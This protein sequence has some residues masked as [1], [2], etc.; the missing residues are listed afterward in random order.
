[1]HQRVGQIEIMEAQHA[2]LGLYLEII[3]RPGTLIAIAATA[4]TATTAPATP[5]VADGFV[6]LFVLI[7][8]CCLLLR[9]THAVGVQLP[10]L[11]IAP[12]PDMGERRRQKRREYSTGLCLKF[13]QPPSAL[14]PRQTAGRSRHKM[15][16]SQSSTLKYRPAPVKNRLSNITKYMAAN[17][18]P[19]FKTTKLPFS[20]SQP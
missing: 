16:A 15:R 13:N 18:M 12:V 8:R 14:A 5:S 19:L 10:W 17:S 7:S 2:R 9:F 20:V 3:K 4:T 11:S 1:M 6:A